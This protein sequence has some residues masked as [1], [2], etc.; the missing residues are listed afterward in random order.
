M[1]KTTD[2][3]N[4]SLP[5]E[6]N[7]TIDKFLHTTW[8]HKLSI[9]SAREELAK[10]RLKSEGQLPELKDRLI[11]YIKGDWIQTDFDTNFIIS[12]NK[13]NMSEKF[14]FCKPDKFSGAIHES[15]DTFINKYNR[16][17]IIN[18]WSSEQKKLFLA[19]YLTETALKFYE[20]FELNYPEA[21]WQQIEDALRLEFEPTAQKHMLRIML[22]K[23]K[24][25]HDE[26]VISYIND[27]ENMCHK[28]DPNM[29]Q[30]ELVHTIMKGLKPEIARYVGILDNNNIQDL[31]RNIRKYESVEFMI[32]GRI[33]QSPDEIRNN[34]TREHI[35]SIDDNKI[36]KQM[37][38]M[39]S[40]IS[41][42]ESI[43]QKF[44]S[45][46]DY[47]SHNE[48][49]NKNI[50]YAQRNTKY[51]KFEKPCEH[52]NMYNHT[53]FNCKWKLICDLCHKRYHTSDTCYS[54][55]SNQK[56]D[57]IG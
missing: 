6:D 16:A 22:E 28:I 11:R 7:E 40:Q 27:T 21:N 5:R 15:I 23:R 24:Q 31:K 45:N 12:N 26:S 50:P 56:N 51:R 39:A 34:I 18:S 52:C 37:E 4:E 49:N 1:G 41:K 14:P 46:N 33:T 29:N 38:N 55:T 36:I 48:N 47:Q 43:I 10:R 32:N 17:S 42:L 35:N 13:V 53:S 9:N 20:N 30:F 54:K 2:T 57:L 25:L 8:A 3:Q 19:I 44:T